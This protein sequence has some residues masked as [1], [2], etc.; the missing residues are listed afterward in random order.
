V[1][2]ERKQSLTYVCESPV[3]LEKR[4]FAIARAIMRHLP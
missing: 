2:D 4:A 1:F 3:I